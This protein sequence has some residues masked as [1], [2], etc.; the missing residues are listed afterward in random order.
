MITESSQ[1][2]V[3]S[4]IRD[5][6][7][8]VCQHLGGRRVSLHFADITSLLTPVSL[9]F[10]PDGKTMASGELPARKPHAE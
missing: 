8:P 5:E 7:R 1:S 9:R 10:Q 6:E 2:H 4:Q 3:I